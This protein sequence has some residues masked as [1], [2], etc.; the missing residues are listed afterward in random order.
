[1]GPG[2]WPCQAGP[3]QGLRRRPGR[4]QGSGSESQWPCPNY[5][6]TV[7]FNE[8]QLGAAAPRRSE[9]GVGCHGH[10]CAAT[11]ASLMVR[12]SVKG[13]MAQE[14]DVAMV[15]GKEGA[16]E[17]GRGGKLEGRREDREGKR[18]RKRIER[19]RDTQ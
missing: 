7:H 1:M 3:D 8:I 13:G 5:S 16:S 10:G 2:P 6:G 12:L 4:Q 17:R 14:E 9:S 18:E 15:V 11:C 19:G